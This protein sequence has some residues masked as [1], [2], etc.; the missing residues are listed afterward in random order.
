MKKIYTILTLVTL[1][2]GVSSCVKSAVDELEGIYPE[3]ASLNLGDVLSD[4]GITEQEGFNLF[5]VDGKDIS[6]TLTG[7][8]WYLEPGEYVFSTELK[9][10]VLLST[11]T[12]QGKA[13]TK[14]SVSISKD[15]DNYSL[16][17]LVW[18]GEEVARFRA[19]GELVYQYVEIEPNFTFTLSPY[20]DKGYNLT[21]NNLDGSFAANFLI[22]TSGS[23]VGSYEMTSDADNLRDGQAFVGID[24]SFFGLGVM[25]CYFDADGSRWF[26]REGTVVISG[27]ESMY[28]VDVEGLLAINALEQIYPESSISF[29]NAI[30]EEPKP[31]ILEGGRFTHMEV[32][33]EG[34]N[35]HTLSL[36]DA[37]GKDAGKIMIDTAP[38]GG[39]IGTFE[40]VSPLDAD[41]IG[42]YILG[43]D[44]SAFG[45]GL[46]G[47]YLVIDGKQYLISGGQLT[48]AAVG[49]TFTITLTEPVVNGLNVSSIE[50]SGLVLEAE[51]E[52]PKEDV[53]FEVKGGTYTLTS[54]PKADAEGIIEH[55]FVFKDADGNDAGQLLVWSSDGTYTGIWPYLAPQATP[56]PGIFLGGLELDLS[57][58]GLGVSNLGSYF[59]KDGKTYL[60]NAGTAIVAEEDGKL[61]VLI[62]GVEAATGASAG[63]E[64]SDVTVISFSEMEAYVAPV[65]DSFTVE[66]G[67]YTIS[68][69]EKVNVDEHTIQFSDS[70]G[71]FVAQVVLRTEKGAEL[72]GNYTVAGTDEAAGT[73]VFGMDFFGM[74]NIGTYYVKDGVT[75]YVTGGTLNFVD[76]FTIFGFSMEDAVSA[77]KDGNAGA[78]SIGISGMT[79]AE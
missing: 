54:A 56:A 61:G 35:E 40:G 45:M 58:F 39:V 29:S 17:G 47:S 73:Y 49:E 33:A 48:I 34:I 30:K 72:S 8:N 9:N 21:L 4:G 10:H 3:V 26:I 67:T 7:K 79:K 31:L 64:A 59:I 11:S 42:K 6:F 41:K 20:E 12:F 28:S 62:S 25:G 13:I 51:P 65:V 1:V 66:G 68:K 43:L 5:K 38:L 70:E 22:I 14:G 78:A 52:K 74:M 55:T 44:A 71:N 75:Y 77:D 76:F 16:S 23:V 37:N 15:G 18:M 19:S 50:I 69:E 32:T 63:S 60:V 46:L 36:K 27:D 2:F 57:A 53:V 24:L